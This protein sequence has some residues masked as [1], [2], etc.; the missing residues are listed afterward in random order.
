[1]KHQAPYPLPPIDCQE[2]AR[3]N[4]E[5]ADAH[6]QLEARRLRRSKLKS[7]LAA[8]HLRLSAKVRKALEHA[9]AKPTPRPVRAVG[10]FLPGKP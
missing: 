5:A 7:S 1:M 3:R 8:K 2:L 6:R 10:F 9:E 4:N